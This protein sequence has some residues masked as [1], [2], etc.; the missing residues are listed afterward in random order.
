MAPAQAPHREAAAHQAGDRPAGDATPTA[1]SGSHAAAG[2]GAS[3]AADTFSAAT[4]AGRVRAEPRPVTAQ[5]GMP[6]STACTRRA[7]EFSTGP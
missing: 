4:A 1:A 7:T 6:L 5:F 2:G 3:A